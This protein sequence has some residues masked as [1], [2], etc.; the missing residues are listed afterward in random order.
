MFANNT[1]NLF[2]RDFTNLYFALVLQNV[3]TLSVNL[4]DNIMLGAYSESALSGATA[5][6]QVQFVFQQIIMAL[7]DGLIVLA[8]QY[9]GKKLTEPLKYIFAISMQLAIIIT[10]ALFAVTA[11]FPSKILMFFTSDKEIISEGC[12]YLSIVK[13]SYFFF[14]VSSI[15]ISYLMSAQ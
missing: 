8:S 13:Y 9:W 7:G 10:V 15:I 2:Y 4:V 3:I 14:A 12:K 11:F 6:N 5:A 1:R